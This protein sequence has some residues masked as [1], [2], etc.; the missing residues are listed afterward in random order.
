MT[1]SRGR[2]CMRGAYKVIGLQIVAALLLMACD[3][4]P[5]PPPPPT[6][7]AGQHA[8]CA[9]ACARWE[10]LGCESGRVRDRCVAACTVVQ[11]HPEVLVWN[12]DCRARVA[13]CGEIDHCEGL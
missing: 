10:A 2:A 3:P 11:A 9:D 13:S 4:K 1:S 7:D 12:L 8:T 6:I 5:L